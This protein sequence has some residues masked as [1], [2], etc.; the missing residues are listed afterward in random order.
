M[1]RVVGMNV[2][3][4]W[5]GSWVNRNTQL[6]IFGPTLKLKCGRDTERIHSWDPGG[7]RYDQQRHRLEKR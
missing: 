4:E 1:G 7:D 6:M 3:V 2:P 5:C